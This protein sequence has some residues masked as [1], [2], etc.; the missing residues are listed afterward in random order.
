MEGGADAAGVFEDRYLV[1]N[2]VL[3]GGERVQRDAPAFKRAIRLAAMFVFADA[4][5]LPSA[6]WSPAW[7]MHRRDTERSNGW[8]GSEPERRVLL[9]ESLNEWLL[10]ASPAFPATTL[11]L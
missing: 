3:V 1:V 9:R 8:C 5:D 2:D 7:V 10:K 4:L 6:L 11:G